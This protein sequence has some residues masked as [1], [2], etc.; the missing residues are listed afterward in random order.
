MAS[1]SASLLTAELAT[2]LGLVMYV[3]HRSILEDL[4]LCRTKRNL[5]LVLDILMDAV[6]RPQRAES[7]TVMHEGPLHVCR[8]LG[9]VEGLVLWLGGA[10]QE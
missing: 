2:V 10:A 7:Q 6:N 4:T 9:H 3:A 8:E 5:W 1:F